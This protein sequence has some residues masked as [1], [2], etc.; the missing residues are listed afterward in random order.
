MNRHY[1]GHKRISCLNFEQIFDFFHLNRQ[2]LNLL[3][4]R[5][6][7]DNRKFCDLLGIY[8]LNENANE[9]GWIIS[10]K[11]DLWRRLGEV[12]KYSLIIRGYATVNCLVRFMR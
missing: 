1:W 7:V 10:C 2:W 11:N 4:G 6:T 9:D 3:F 12:A 8:D 5:K